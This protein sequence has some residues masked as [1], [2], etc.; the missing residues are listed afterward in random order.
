MN[1]QEPFRAGDAA[2]GR[3]AGAGKSA[4]GVELDEHAFPTLAALLRMPPGE[5]RTAVDA[6]AAAARTQSKPAARQA[7]QTAVQV[8]NE[9]Y[10]TKE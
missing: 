9:L 1:P 4:R 2:R 8:L 10:R 3:S 7:L 6:L 5:F